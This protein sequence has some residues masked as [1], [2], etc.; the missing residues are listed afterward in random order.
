M[1]AG[2]LHV[3]HDGADVDVPAVADRV[4]I[5]LHGPLQEAVD[6][7]RVAGRGL[8]RRLDVALEALPVVHDLHGPPAQHVGGP[9]QHRIPDAL[10]DGQRLLLA[11]RRAERRRLQAELGQDA[12]EALPVLGQVDGLLGS[13]HDGHAGLVQL[14]RDLERRL[15]AELDDDPL[16]LLVLAR[17]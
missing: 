13:P 9:H 3:L 8:H 16:G 17:C 4:H 15:A 14:L 12:A 1:D 10:G 11:A 6:E 2:L 7:H 5:H